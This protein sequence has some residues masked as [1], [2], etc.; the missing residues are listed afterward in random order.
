MNDEHEHEPELDPV[1]RLRAADP[2]AGVEPR[3][4]FADEVVARAAAETATES[5][6]V[7]DLG[8]QR[9]RRR[10]RW[11][12]IAAVAASLVVVGAVGYGVGTTTG[13]AT[14]LADGA[15]PPISLQSGSGVGATDQGMMQGDAA[16][17]EQ[18]K[19]MPGAGA[20]ASG[21]IAPYGFGR[22]VFSASGLSDAD[23]TARAYAFDARAASDA[24]TVAALAAALGV[25]GTPELKDG[26]WTAGP[27]DGT[28][29]SLWVSL[30][31]TLSFSY[32]DPR[33]NPW[34]CADGAETCT[35]ETGNL[36]S[37]EA[38]IDA[39]R[40]LLVAAG[41]NPAAFEFTS[42]TYE[43]AVTRS[44]QAWPVVDG[45]RIDQGWTVELSNDGMVSAYGALAD[46][47]SIGDYPVVSEQDAFARLS[48]P[49]F[50]AAMTNLPIALR[51]QPMAATSEWVPPTEPPAAPTTGTSLAWPVNHV[52][53]VDAR[54]GLA[55]QWQPDGSVLV[56]P[57]YEFTDAD[58]GTWSVIA[59]ADAKLDFAVE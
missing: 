14:N 24:E 55:S 10:P 46:L 54:L 7:A 40:S 25:V 39:L 50:G 4:G 12:S 28:G 57:A 16:V 13:G 1:Q 38:A 49:R 35:P 52:E 23:G 19:M 53:I 37:E 51:D 33:I 44:A 18:A 59:V 58:G 32:S 47:V 29:P 41:R 8:A 26:S 34:Q 15:A 2:A 3:A 21:L 27:Q 6:P 42:E 20:G 5:A 56:V 31:G 48:D 36:P 30:D 11:L 45:Q 43:G 9:A 22:N 17:P